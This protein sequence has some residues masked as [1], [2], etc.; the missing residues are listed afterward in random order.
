MALGPYAVM[1]VG[2]FVLPF[3]FLFN[4]GLNMEGGI[5]NVV[6]ALFF[7]ASMVSFAS[8]A[9]HGLIGKHT[10]NWPLRL[11]LFA[12]TVVTMVP[13][14]EVQLA[15]TI[16]GAL[17]LASKRRGNPFPSKRGARA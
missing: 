2:S 17:I 5:V 4:P 16:L 15:A 10:I 7:G 3:F 11:V 14:I 8:F 1:A 12:C 9:L 13:R 6:T